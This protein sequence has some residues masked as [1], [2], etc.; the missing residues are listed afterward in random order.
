MGN[1]RRKSDI[2]EVAERKLR[3]DKPPFSEGQRGFIIETITLLHCILIHASYH[4]YLI[5]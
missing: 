4:N 5:R 3:E 1:E 2:N